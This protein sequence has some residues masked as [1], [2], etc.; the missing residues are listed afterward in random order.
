MTNS[1]QEI[2]P[3]FPEIDFGTEDLYDLHDKLQILLDQDKRVVPLR[4][5]DGIAWAILRYSDLMAAYRDEGTLPV[6]P[7]YIRHSEPVQG[8]TV[9]TMEG[10]EHR[11]N[12]FLV[13]KAFQ[14]DAIRGHIE[15]LLVPVANELIDGFKGRSEVDLVV[16]FSY[17]Y[18]FQVIRQML[19]VPAGDEEQLHGWLH[20]LFMYPGDP[21]RALRGSKAITNYLK[22]IVEARRRQPGD[23]LISMLTQAESEGEHLSDEEIFS[24]IRLLFPAGADTTFLTMGAMFYEVLSDPDIKSQIL[25][26]DALDKPTVEEALRMHGATCLLPRYTENAVTIGGVDIP[27]ESWLLYG[28]QTANRDP[29][30]FPNPSVFDIRRNPK[31]LLAFG[32]GSHF[33]L[34][35]HLARAELQIALRLIL[36]RLKNVRLKDPDMAPPMKGAILR[37]AGTLPVIFDEVV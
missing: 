37:G 4:F 3:E 16:E 23:D 7:A 29:E 20:E 1:P 8:R 30:M 28:N 34:G 33:C 21:E 17:R 26:D 22:P 15:S 18:P 24:F 5:G 31:K 19:D 25:A 9:L 35:S 13:S 2:T 11:V 10:Q 14:P 12:R 6:S 32:A 27:A 36:T